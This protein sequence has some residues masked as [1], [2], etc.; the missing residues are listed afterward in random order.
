MAK[1]DGRRRKIID[2]WRQR[3]LALNDA[4]RAADVSGASGD[5]TKITLERKALARAIRKLSSDAMT[6]A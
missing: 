4:Y 1:G 5:M 3:I 2:G 6:S